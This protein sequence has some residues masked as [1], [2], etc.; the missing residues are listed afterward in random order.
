MGGRRE[1]EGEDRTG[2]QRGWVRDAPAVPL[3]GRFVNQP[4]GRRWGGK[5]RC[6]RD[7]D[8]G[9]RSVTSASASSEAMRQSDAAQGWT[10]EG[11]GGET[12]IKTGDRRFG[13]S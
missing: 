3:F 11:G 8:A 10:E 4:E 9:R 13:G 5:W 2:K 7:R 12:D 1:E 6:G